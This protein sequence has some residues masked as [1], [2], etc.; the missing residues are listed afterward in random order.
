MSA[1]GTKQTAV[2]RPG[3]IYVSRDSGNTW[4]AKESRRNWSLVAMS[5]DGT[6]QTAVAHGGQIYVSTDSGNTWTAK[7]SN[8]TWLSVAMSADGIKQTAVVYNNGQIYVSTDSGNTWTARESN[9]VWR[10]V[11]MSADGTIQTALAYNGQIYV[12][13]DSG[14]TWTA[15]ELTRDWKSVAMSADGTK[16][17]AVA[18]NER[19]YVCSAD[20]S[21]AYN[22]G[23]GTIDPGAKLEVNGEVKITDGSQG[24]GRVLTSDATGLASWQAP[25]GG[26]GED[27]DWMVFGSDM[28]SIPTGDIGIGT[29]SPQAKLDV[30]GQ[31]KITDG[32]QGAGRVLT[33][34]ATGLASW[35]TP[36]GGGGLTLPYAG[37]TSTSGSA[38][39]ISNNGSGHAIWGESNAGDHGVLG[40]KYAGVFG[41]GQSN[42]G[43]Y[44][45]SGE[46]HG[47][48]GKGAT[49]VC[50]E[51]DNG[52]GVVGSTGHPNKSGV[53]GWSTSGAG[54][55]G[56]SEAVSGHGVEGRVTA[57]H[58][59][60]VYGNA[61]G[62]NSVGVYGRS[63]HGTGVEGRTT[64]S[65]EWV[66]AIYG[67][68][69]GAGDGVYGWSQSRHG[70]F[71][72][73]QSQN[74]DHAGLYGINQGAGPGIYAQAGSSG[75][76]AILKGN[77][78]IRSATTGAVV[79]EL[80]EG[81][82]Y[83]EGFDVSNKSGIA[84]G[85][86]LVID[87]E[88]PGKLTISAK[89][90]D[91]KVAGIVAGAKDQGSGIR[92]GAGQFDY[93]VALAGRV[94]CSVDTTEAGVEPG[95][96]LT[97]SAVPGYAM[98]A[99][100][101]TRAQGAILGKAMEKLEKGKKSQILVL[102]TLQ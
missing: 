55:T 56:R 19:I 86:V 15:K 45:Y 5:A 65:N 13:T 18:H 27:N 32:S 69:A 8:R 29:N 39:S 100:D 48:Y 57:A 87:A 72:V 101:Y 37:S 46:N 40:H 78:Q 20:V 54:V 26:G 79:A 7:E 30:I 1:D 61:T 49:G 35:Q 28:Y 2:V 84:P 17:T 51:S 91:T 67:R 53:Y 71:G 73:T 12:S 96:L 66:S 59:R 41:Y 64:S 93:D 21:V 25:T 74:P 11:A 23:I 85:T 33:S 44:G 99:A 70:T 63:D 94:Y 31:V 4:T 75:Y 82:D 81:L 80:G 90:Y 77:V 9:R 62:S 98:K 3:Q 36:T 42:W 50:G 88:N 89:P 14:N 92:L 58:S 102:V 22:V 38:F 97:T 6:K 47:V 34:D 10:S 76:S 16:Q 52:D 24:A 68:N 83:A 95:D 60:G 43:V